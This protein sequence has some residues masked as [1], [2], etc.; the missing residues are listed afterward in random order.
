MNC[1]SFVRL[2]FTTVC[3][4]ALIGC[5]GGGSN[6]D[7][8]A[9]TSNVRGLDAEGRVAYTWSFDNDDGSLRGL[10]FLP[11]EFGSTDQ[12][13]RAC[14]GG[15]LTCVVSQD[16]GRTGQGLRFDPSKTQSYAWLLGGD[17]KWAS[18]P[19]R[20]L[21]FSPYANF[22]PGGKL[23]HR[24]TVALQIKADKIESGETYHLFG[25]QDPVGS[26]K[27]ASFHLRLVDG[28]P[29][30]S[31]YPDGTYSPVPDFVMKAPAPL[32]PDAWHH[33][34]V[35]YQIKPVNG[36]EL[37]MVAM[38]VDGQLVL[39]QD[40]NKDVPPKGDPEDPPTEST[41]SQLN[42]SCEPY[43]LGGLTTYG[44]EWPDD[45]VGKVEASPQGY[46]FPGVIDDLLFSNRALTAADIAALAA[47]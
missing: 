9:S 10:S 12:T 31:L 33:I 6:S 2:S 15:S 14:F 27:S 38:Y 45:G 11:V 25:T 8:A 21:S 24:M 30:I 16:A 41:R 35:V 43:F 3:A 28:Y 1:L 40:R 29:T 42:E 46:V 22:T 34:A 20:V 44:F 23:D 17:K 26:L 13:L 36:K 47:R 39:E 19:G 37:V 4:A 7:A 18:C 32:T 5:G